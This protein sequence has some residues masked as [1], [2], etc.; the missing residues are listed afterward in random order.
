[1]GGGGKGGKS[2]FP[3]KHGRWADLENVSKFEL[4]SGLFQKVCLIF[5]CKITY[6]RV[7]SPIQ[8]DPLDM[9]SSSSFSLQKWESECRCPFLFLP[10]NPNF[11]C[12]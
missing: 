10:T 8:S 4:A 9:L 7:V 1:M 5:F 3:H 11:G 6:S 2:D 12:T